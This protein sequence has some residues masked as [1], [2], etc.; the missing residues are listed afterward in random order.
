MH[1]LIPGDTYSLSFAISSEIA[2]GTGS[3]VQVS[4][5]SGSSTAAQDFTA[6]VSSNWGNWAT[7]STSFVATS[8]SVTLQFLNL[9]IESAASGDLGLDNVIVTGPGGGG[10]VPEPSTWA[11]ML[12]GFAGLGFS[13][14]RASRKSASFAT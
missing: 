2:F 7:E 3:V 10:T 11:M 9:A 1:G 8:S 4:Y 6:P 5:L 13:G 12:L 14:Y